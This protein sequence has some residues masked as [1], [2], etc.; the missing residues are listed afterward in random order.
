LEDKLSDSERLSI[1]RILELWLASC[2]EEKTSDSGSTFLVVPIADRRGHLLNLIQA[3]VTYGYTQDEIKT[4]S[5]SMKVV[6]T[7]WSDLIKKM[8]VKKVRESREI[9]R[10]Q[11]EKAIDEYF[12]SEFPKYVKPEKAVPPVAP[13]PKKEKPL[14]LDP[15]DRLQMDTSDVADAP[16]DFDF[17]DEIGVD[18]TFVTGQKDE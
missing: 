12:V 14:E 9:T 8:S 2:G 15:K 1:D 4:G 7:C 3:M 10:Q 11:W 16:I 17:L 6:K 13:V 18:K 5:V